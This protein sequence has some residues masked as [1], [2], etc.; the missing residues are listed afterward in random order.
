[1]IDNIFSESEITPGM[2]QNRI[3]TLSIR[4]LYAGPIPLPVVPT[5]LSAESYNRWNGKI[6]EALSLMKSLFPSGLS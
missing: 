6:T 3:P 5:I 2:S 1:M 4:S